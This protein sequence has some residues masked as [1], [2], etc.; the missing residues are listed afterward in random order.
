LGEQFGINRAVGR[1]ADEAAFAQ[2]RM[3][4]DDR[5]G[6]LA[7]TLPAGLV[8]PGHGQAARRFVDVQP[9]RIMA[10]GAIHLFF[11]DWVMLGKLKLGFD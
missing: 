2:R 11:K 9:V 3:L 7:V 5:L 10:L 4:E 6:L 8:A 1:V